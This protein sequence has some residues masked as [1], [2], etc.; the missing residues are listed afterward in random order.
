MVEEVKESAAN[1]LSL[2]ISELKADLELKEAKF[3]R[4]V[5][6]MHTNQAEKERMLIQLIIEKA[7]IDVDQI[8]AQNQEQASSSPGHETESVPRDINLVDLVD[9]LLKLS[10]ANPDGGSVLSQHERD[11]L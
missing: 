1:A 8:L 5:D 4:D 10:R 2:E 6:Q 11:L 3:K 9:Y 7:A